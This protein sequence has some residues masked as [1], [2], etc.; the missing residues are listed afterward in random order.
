MTARGSNWQIPR[1]ANKES[2]SEWETVFPSG[3]FACKYV[4]HPREQKSSL[5]E[6]TSN[7][8]DKR[9]QNENNYY[10]LVTSSLKDNYPKTLDTKLFFKGK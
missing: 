3:S 2:G 7:L 9:K 4:P 1:T 8:S 5:Q 6:E 10:T